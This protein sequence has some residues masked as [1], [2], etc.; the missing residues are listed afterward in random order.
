MYAMVPVL[1]IAPVTVLISRAK[2]KSQSLKKPSFA[3]IIFPGFTSLWIMTRIESSSASSE[4]IV[5][6]LM[7]LWRNANADA[8]SLIIVST[9]AS[10]MRRL[11]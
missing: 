2:L 11:L 8:I 1:D 7:G 3:N 5:V 6:K 4:S 9:V 10:G